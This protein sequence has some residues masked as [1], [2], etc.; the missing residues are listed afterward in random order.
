MT[1]DDY[2]IALD[3]LAA[4]ASALVS[5][6]E[7]DAHVASCAACAAYASLSR[8]VSQTM[9]NTLT[10]SPPPLDLE[11]MRVRVRR[12]RRQVTRGLLLW[13]LLFG[14]GLMVLNRF[15]VG[16]PGSWSREILSTALA[17][18][19]AFALVAVQLRRHATRLTALEATGDAE[20]LDGLRAELDRRIHNERQGWWVLPIVLVLFHWQF[21]G[22]AAPPV[23]ILVYEVCLLALVPVGIVRYRR[24]KRERALL[25]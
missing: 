5:A 16:W 20:L 3:Q 11:A 9:M 8:K 17:T 24:A 25:G 10:I 14:V 23:P 22:L 2:Q 1:C 6:A 13:P 19:F 18:A 21:A 7:V 12:F 4:G 15:V